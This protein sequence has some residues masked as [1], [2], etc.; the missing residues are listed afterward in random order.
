[1]IGAHTFCHLFLRR[2]YTDRT[3]YITVI[4]SLAVV[5][6]ELCIENFI[7]AKP[8]KRHLY[9]GVAGYW[10]WITPMHRI[11]RYTTGYLFMFISVGFSFILYSL[12]FFRLRGNISVSNVYKITFHRRPKV[13]AGRTC[14]GTYITTDDRRIESHLTT[15][16]K[17]MLWYPIVYSILV[18]PVAASRFSE[19]SGRP[20]PF[21]V[22]M[23]VASVF[24][25]HGFFNTVLFCTTRDILP[26]GWKQRF[27]L[28]ATASTRRCDVDPSRRSD[29]TWFTAT[30]TGT[31]GIETAPIIR[32]VGVGEG[33]GI[34]YVAEP[35]T[36]YVKFGPPISPTLPTSPLRAHG[37]GGHRADAHEHHIRRLSSS[38]PQGASLRIHFEGGEGDE[39]SGLSVG[40]DS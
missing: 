9:Y 24:M 29:R 27:G 12:V 23:I 38:A 21:S 31:V 39:D 20:V 37:G 1:V 4:V 11:E 16:A 10:C 35:S 6:L 25:L 8:Q 5:L 13:R 26:G 7:L 17:H 30:R 40:Q 18:L 19:F 28:G 3:C 33:L 34:K 15:L 22:T 32:S 14:G 2:K 36:S